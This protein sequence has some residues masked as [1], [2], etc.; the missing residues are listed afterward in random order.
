MVMFVMFSA[1]LVR[2]R[3]RLMLRMRH[4]KTN[5]NRRRRGEK[6]LTFIEFRDSIPRKEYEKLCREAK[7]ADCLKRAFYELKKKHLFSGC[8][9]LLSSVYYNP[10][11]VI[12]KIKHNVL[13]MK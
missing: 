3:L 12:D 7:S 9:A 4:I 2:K 6:E 13:R 1:P 11:Y 5:L 10:V 8:R